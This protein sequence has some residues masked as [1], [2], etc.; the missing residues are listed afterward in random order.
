MGVDIILGSRASDT[1]AGQSVETA[2]QALVVAG[3][4]VEVTRGSGIV[5]G[6]A[7]GIGGRVAGD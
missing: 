6:I 2:D 3:N 5:T 7:G 4:A 1:V